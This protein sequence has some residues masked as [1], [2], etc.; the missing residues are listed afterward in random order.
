MI[1]ADEIR[2]R[3]Q[4]ADQEKIVA[5]ANVAAIVGER[6]IALG[7]AQERLDEARSAVGVSISEATELMNLKELAEFTESSIS[8][9]TSLSKTKRAPARKPQRGRGEKWVEHCHERG[10]SS[11]LMNERSSCRCRS[12]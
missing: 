6:L 9:L 7:E 12:H 10:R 2:K 1:T 4:R 11:V 3:V 8:K 5:R